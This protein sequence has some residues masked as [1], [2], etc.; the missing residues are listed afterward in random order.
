MYDTH[1][2]YSYTD[3]CGRIRSVTTRWKRYAVDDIAMECLLDTNQRRQLAS[4]HRVSYLIQSGRIGHAEIQACD[5]DCMKRFR[6]RS[7]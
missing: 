1:Y 2:H 4:A 3:L 6:V 7:R 5:D